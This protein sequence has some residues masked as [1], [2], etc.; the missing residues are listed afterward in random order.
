MAQPPTHHVYLA[1]R[2]SRRRELLKQIGVSF[3]VLLLREGPGRSAD[4]DESPLPGEAP[5][6]YV[7]RIARLKAQAGWQRLFLRRLIRFPVLSA[8]TAVAVDEQILG[9]PSGREQAVSFLQTLSGRTHLVHSAVAVCFD[10]RL[11]LAVSTTEVRFRELREAEI[12]QY[13]GSGE[14]MDK[15]GGYAIQGRAAAF[16]ASISGSYSGVM[17]LPLFETSELLAKFGY[18]EP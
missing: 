16:I 5:R 18:S 4:V 15:A 17:G 8:D 9:K 10:S 12:R 7:T 3:E 14:P 1:S 2:S 6:D 13:V 11:E